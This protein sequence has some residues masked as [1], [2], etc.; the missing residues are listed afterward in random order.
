M[1]DEEVLVVS[2]EISFPKTRRPGTFASIFVWCVTAVTAALLASA[3]PARAHHHP[4]TM[5][6]DDM[7][8]QV[9]S[10][11]A[12]H[13]RVGVSSVAAA[14]DTFTMVNFRFDTDGNAS[15][16]IDTAKIS[17]GE[18][19]L[20][21]WITGFH[22]TTDGIDPSDPDAGLMWDQP[23]DSGHTTFSFT[24]NS[25]GTFPFFCRPH[26]GLGM[27][28]VV[29]VH[30]PVGVSPGAAPRLGFLGGPVPNPTR[31]EVSFRF[32]TGAPGMVR[33]EVFDA[34]GG[35]VGLVRSGWMEAGVHADRWNA[36]TPAGTK[37]APGTYFL[38]LRAPGI[39]E[40][41]RF[42]ITR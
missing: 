25:A 5:T 9:E 26:G 29:V 15:T 22:T 12:S 42:T 40:S 30:A 20:W 11:F 41:R 1:I 39:A 24:F 21:R 3:A 10:W 23:M 7:R 28:G 31:S 2:H 13:P 19:I 33:I 18:T 14:A 38:R 16:Q 4:A 34:R 37:A 27:R 17:V 35:R 36:R 6:D 8:R 32:A